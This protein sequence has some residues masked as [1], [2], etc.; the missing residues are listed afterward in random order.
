MREFNHVRDEHT[1]CAQRSPKLRRPL[2]QPEIELSLHNVIAAKATQ[3]G[4]FVHAAWRRRPRSSGCVYPAQAIVVGFH[5]PSERQQVALCQS[6]ELTFRDDVA[7]VL[8]FQRSG[9]S[10]ASPESAA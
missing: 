4:G 6:S 7:S 10:P 1:M 5:Q 8:L 2:I 9:F 3:V